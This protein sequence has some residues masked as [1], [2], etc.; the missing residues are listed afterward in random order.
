MTGKIADTVMAVRNG[1]QIVRKYQPVVQNPKSAAQLEARAK[2]KLISQLAAVMAPVI[3]IP[4]E[5]I[6]TSR[7]QFVKLNYGS[8]SY[9]D[10]TAN[11]QLT[12]VK[13]TKGVVSL[14][15]LQITRDTNNITA[16]LSSALVNVNRVV[17]A[18]FV[19]QD[20]NTLRLASTQV[21]SAPGTGGTFNAM[22]PPVAT[23]GVV[24]AYG[25]RDNTEAAR[26]IFGDMQVP[27]AESV[28][29]LIVS[30]VLLDTDVTLTETR[31][32]AFASA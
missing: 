25:V 3:A 30:R 21:V 32:S 8:M 14:P 20:D 29:K 26:V 7:N 17:Y 19:K 13:L 5:G 1:E 16:A 2:L 24:Y 11:V 18:M 23:E 15:A 4:R 9:A 12:S 22:F 31:A 10:N 28:A 6:V 27:T